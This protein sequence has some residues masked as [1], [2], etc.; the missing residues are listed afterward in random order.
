MAQTI[1]VLNGP[2][3]NLL[4]ERQPHIY[5]HAT[6]ADVEAL[7]RQRTQAHGLELAFHQS[8]H[9]G[10]LVDLIQ[11]ARRECAAIVINPA[12]YSH[13]SVAILDALLT[14]EGPVMEVHI[15]NIAKREGYRRHSY[16]SEGATGVIAGLGI[17]GYGLAIDAAAEIL[18]KDD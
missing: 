18:G 9:E 14:F 1:Q 10:I 3:L 11:E 16:I 12:G 7:C 13:T 15:S 5:G 4:G 6:L 17:R 2:N 8:N